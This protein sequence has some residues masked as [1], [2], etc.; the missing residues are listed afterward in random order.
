MGLGQQAP[1]TAEYQKIL[2]ESLADQNRGGQGENARY[3]C[4]PSGMPRIMAL[5]GPAEFAITP[6]VTYIYF[7][8][9][10]PRRI[11]TDGRSF[12]DHD[13]NLPSM[14]TRSAAGPTKTATGATTCSM[15]RLAT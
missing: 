15:S 3:S 8:N 1:L 13:R 6:K 7:E 5:V 4:F 11:Y 10:M 12:P 14:A 9:T 2:Q